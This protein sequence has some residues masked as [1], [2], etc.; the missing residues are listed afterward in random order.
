VVGSKNPVK[1]S[2]GQRALSQWFS[3]EHVMAEGVSADSGVPDQPMT[4]AETRLGAVNRVHDCL[5]KIKQGELKAADYVVAFEGGVDIFTD[6]PATFAYVAI[7]NGEKLV[8]GRSGNLLIANSVFEALGQGK[9]LGH[10]IDALYGTTN[11]KQ[12]GGAI[13]ILTKGL[14]TRQSVYVTAM[15]MAMSAFEY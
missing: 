3:H 14:A 1:V 9:E 10:V 2:A 7:S 6:G 12:K 11:I 5:L 8:V 15:L 13:G 4:E